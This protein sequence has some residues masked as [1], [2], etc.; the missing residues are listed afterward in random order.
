MGNEERTFTDSLNS[1]HE[2][3]GRMDAKI[4]D[5]K[6]IRIKAETAG[7]QAT[8]ALQHIDRLDGDMKELKV[9]N[10]AGL[11]GIEKRISD[12][13]Q[14]EVANKRWIVGLAVPTFIGLIGL[15]DRF[16]V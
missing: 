16:F 1:I 11:N 9:F 8:Q 3:L 13:E 6:D 12:Q 14:K 2:K 7:L 4:D 5:I 15:V 10:Q